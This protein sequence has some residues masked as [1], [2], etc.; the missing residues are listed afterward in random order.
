MKW[1]KINMIIDNK[2]KRNFRFYVILITKRN[3][4]TFYRIN[5]TSRHQLRT[6]SIFRSAHPQRK[7]PIIIRFTH[8][9][10]FK[11]HK[12]FMKWSIL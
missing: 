12:L 2:D 1:N 8:Q 10:R 9:K 7:I 4:S 11:K 3:S 5:D 6:S